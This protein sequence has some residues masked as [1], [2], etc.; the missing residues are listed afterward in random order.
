MIQRKKNC[1]EKTCVDAAIIYLFPVITTLCGK[2]TEV[3]GTSPDV[4]KFD[5]WSLRRMESWRM[6]SRL[7]R[8][9]TVGPAAA[10]KVDGSPRLHEMFTEDDLR[11]C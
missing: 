7:H 11:S 6:V 10:R 5:G 4:R 3:I 8:K 1:T 2:M 9:L